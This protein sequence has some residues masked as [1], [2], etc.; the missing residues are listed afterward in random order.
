MSTPGS[1]SAPPRSRRIGIFLRTESR[2]ESSGV[3]AHALARGV[4]VVVSDLGAMSELPDEVAVKVGVAI[5]ATELAAV[6]RTLLADHD[7]RAA[8]RRSAL[9]F[10]VRET[11]TAQARRLVDAV[12]D[13]D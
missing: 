11:P 3:V 5:T 13:S 7:R 6:I 9:A 12:F 1:A 10:A 4:P 2:G 8:M